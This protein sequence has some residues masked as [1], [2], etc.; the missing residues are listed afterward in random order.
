MENITGPSSVKVPTILFLVGEKGCIMTGMNPV[1]KKGE[2]RIPY[3]GH[4][5]YTWH[6]GHTHTLVK[7]QSEMT[8]R[9]TER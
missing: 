2:K 3:W 9:L 8:Q 6:V 5:N 4:G 7:E 1:F